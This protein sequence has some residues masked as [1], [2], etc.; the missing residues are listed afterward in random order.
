MKKVTVY[1]RINRG[2]YSGKVGDVIGWIVDQG[3]VNGK[4]KRTVFKTQ[5]E[6]DTLA[7]NLNVSIEAKQTQS[8]NDIGEL[9]PLR[10]EL[11]N[12]N[13]KLKQVGAT[14]T[15]AVDFFLAHTVTQ[16][17]VITF[18]R[19]TQLYIESC[20]NRGLSNRY[21]DSLRWLH[22][23]R[24][25]KAF[26]GERM[27]NS[28]T[29]EEITK[30]VFSNSWGPT[31]IINYLRNLNTL[32][33]YCKDNGYIALNP[34][35][36]IERPKAKENE[37]LFLSIKDTKKLLITALNNKMYDRLAINALVLFC[38]IRIE[39]ACKLKWNDIDYNEWTVS[40]S[41]NIAKLGMR[42]INNIPNCCKAWLVCC[43]PAKASD[44][45]TLI[46]DGNAEDKLSWLRSKSG[47]VYP[48]NGCRHSFATYHV[49]LH[50]NAGQ[51][52]VMMGHK[53]NV[54]TLYNHYRNAVSKT[55][56]ERFFNI[57][58]TPKQIEQHK[59]L[60]NKK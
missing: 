6:A 10:F 13:Q 37:S 38:G 25:L 45:D 18:N 19:A 4:R 5:K 9:L 36:K 39:E 12:C 34:I 17:G 49:A 55:D 11:L 26:D 47:I 14:F 56:G 1:P 50:Q 46:I 16:K 7:Y 53:G 41:A 35:T 29:T 3:K 31:T 42:R 24:F 21:I 33:N 15:Q 28:F 54:S 43:R 60:V 48:T 23:P 44:R 32:F 8:V 27:M 40:V 59:K 20:T 57:V 2:D 52:A 22:Y 58:P 51:T 30:H